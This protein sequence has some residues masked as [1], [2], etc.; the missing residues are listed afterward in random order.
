MELIMRINLTNVNYLYNQGTISEKDAVRDV[1][2]SIEKPEF[3]AIVGSTGSGKSTLIQLLNGLKLPTSGTI[4]YDGV[5]IG[6]D[7]KQLRDIRCKVGIVFQYPEYQLFDENVLKD[8]AF[9]P[10]NKGC[11]ND[12]AVE[13]AKNALLATGMTEESFDKSPFDLSGGEKRRVAIAGVIAMDPEILI[14]DEP[15]A[16][17]DPKGKSEILDLINELHKA[18]NMTVIMV[19]H[20]M[21]E[22]AEYA[23]RVIVMHE[24]Q[25]LMDGDPHDVFANEEIIKQA[26]L[27]QPQAADF[28]KKL[29]ID[30]PIKINEAADAIAAWVNK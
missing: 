5:N 7:K 1:T 28:C 19:S 12:E 3:I 23:D 26:G 8:A 15:T 2:L 29:G 24:G 4:T 9:G 17:L 16:G 6:K 22:V 25:I 10:H 20:N 14:M 21:D 30:G 11:S 18:R 13:K 27:N